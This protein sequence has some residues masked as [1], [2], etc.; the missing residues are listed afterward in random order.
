MHLTRWALA[1]AAT[2]LALGLACAKPTKIT[3]A[4]KQIVMNDAGG[5]KTLLAT[6][7]DQKDRPMEKAAVTFT[8]SAPDVAEVDA[9]GKVTAR[10][11]G[12]ATITATSGKA[13]GQ[14]KLIVH[15]VSALN[16]AAPQDGVKGPAG[17]VVPLLVSGTNERGEPA[18]LSGIVFTSE[19]P[20]VATVDN[21]G[22]LTLL[23]SGDTKITAA[24]GK[25]K[26]ELLVPVHILV[27]MAIKVPTPPVQ[28]IR[29]GETA[30]LNVSVLSDLGEP[31]D[32]PFACASSSEKVAAVDKDGNV[33][34]LARGTSEITVTAG[35]AKNTIK[36]VV[37]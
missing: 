25:S 5:T 16:L 15:I 2:G 7:F 17:D 19:A 22:R 29:A 10:G 9:A 23:T 4:P 20:G 30:R 21:Q 1:L 12:E 36:V 37:K 11:S 34:G 14:A 8:S 32:V 6:V 28:M 24:I 18:D 35:T 27:P 13:S 33:T 31:M 26:A 3:V